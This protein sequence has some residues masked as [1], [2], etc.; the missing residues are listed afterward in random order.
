MSRG[1]SPIIAL[2][3]ALTSFRHGSAADASDGGAAAGN[4]AAAVEFIRVHVPAGRIGDLPLEGD[5]WVPMPVADFE[6]AAARF[7]SPTQPQAGP[8]P[9]ADAARYTISMDD[10][11]RLG[12]M[13]EFDVGPVAAMRPQ[14]PLGR[15]DAAVGLVRTAGGLG[16][17]ALFGLPDGGIAMRITGPGTYRCRFTFPPRDEAAAD[18]QLPL[19]PALATRIEL[20]L[21]DGVRPH[22]TTGGSMP[23]MVAPPVTAA[24]VPPFTAAPGVWTIDLAAAEHVGIEIMSREARQP[25]LR[26]WNRVVIRG[27]QSELTARVVPDSA[28]TAGAIA[29]GKEPGLEVTKVRTA[30]AD[31]AAIELPDADPR[32]LLIELPASLVGTTV[33]IDVMG[34]AETASDE[35]NA[36]PI[37]RPGTERWAGGGIAVA[38]EPDD[39]VESAMLEECV[40]VAPE[41][42][43]R[44]PIPPAAA[45]LAAEERPSAVEPAP[46]FFEQQSAAA[47]VALLVRR[48]ITELDAARITTVEIS[49]GAVLGRAACDIRVVSG[50]AFEVTAQL[51][52]GWFIDSV[53]AVDWMGIDAA[54]GMAEGDFGGSRFAE[55][56]PSRAI[57]WRVVRSDGVS[58]LRIGLAEAATRSR[59]RLADHGAPSGRSGRRRVRHRRHGHGAAPG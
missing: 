8:R 50:E 34:V 39:V 51:G 45:S 54:G 2:V 56:D 47:R 55:P 28:W 10:R 58:E 29:L 18:F 21:P 46:L 3:V 30:A 17:A 22:V 43:G 44:W 40:A 33:P 38:I 57:D 12:G 24:G 7:G 42:G 11:G 16:E 14:M 13:L 5:R 32:R 23:A 53:E 4:E 41:V 52:S 26:V 9:L 27:G 35:R 1:W 19:V 25:R 15:I 59:A 6:R 36:V 48:R 37:V 20:T 49:A 31:A